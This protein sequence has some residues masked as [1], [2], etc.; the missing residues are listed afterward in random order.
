MEKKP[1]DVKRESGGGADIGTSQEGAIIELI[2]V[3]ARLIIV[4]EKALY[5]LIMA[6]D[7][8]PERTNYD[9]PQT[10]HKLV[11]NQGWNSETVSK[12]FLTAK[13]FFKGTYFTKSVDTEYALGLSLELLQEVAVLE[14]EVTS[15]I[16]K[17]S[18]V[19]EDYNHRKKVATSYA[20]PTIIDV[21]ARCKT[22]IQKADHIEQILME[23]VSIFYPSSGLTKQSHIPTL[24]AIVKKLYG[25]SDYFVQFLN[26]FEPFMKISR[27]LRNG[28][29]HRLSSV[30]VANFTMQTDFSVLTPTIELNHKHIKMDRMALSSFLPLLLSNLLSLVE[31]TI[32]CIS[33]K[34][35]KS[36]LLSYAVREIPEQLRRNKFVR[37]CFWSPFGDEGYYA[38]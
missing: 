23:I 27:E 38:Q 10:I 19:V 25:E 26:K 4:K 6:D 12:V 8:D 31:G 32:V 18:S 20:L 22:I 36:N 15:Y 2:P 16:N 7:V 5:E 29:D 17:E 30:K 13:T 3:G 37:Y 34:N 24:L 11:L 21:E 14:E 28:L 35:A 33:G 1:I 9:L